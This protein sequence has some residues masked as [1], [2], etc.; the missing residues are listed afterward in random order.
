MQ[1]PKY[2]VQFLRSEALRSSSSS[3]RTG[4][5]KECYID[6]DKEAHVP[7]SVFII[8][9]HRLR[10]SASTVLTATGQ[11]NGRWRILTP[12][13]I[14]T[15]EQENSAQLIT[16]AGGPPKPNLVQIHPLGACGHMG[17]I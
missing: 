8:A 6:R 14:E 4:Q 16:S 12:H 3:S 17:E 15:H 13:K 11:V 1:A 10:G 9:D 7:A 2:D 5:I